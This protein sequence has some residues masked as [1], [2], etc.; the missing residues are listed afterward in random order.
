MSSSP[1]ELPSAIVD[2][3]WDLQET[4]FVSAVGLVILLYDHL[5][6]LPD[7][8]RFIWP[9]EF[10]SSK[11]LFLA[12]RYCVPCIMI[13]HTVQL[14][15][16]SPLQLTDTFCKAWYC[17]G[18]LLGWLTLAINDWLVMLRLWI[19]F[20]RNRAFILCTL[21][22]FIASNTVILVLSGIGFHDMIPTTRF[23]PLVHV[24][25]PD[26]SSNHIRVLW[27]PVLLFQ[28]MM[29]SALGWK[30][31]T[32]TKTFST[33]LRDGYLYFLESSCYLVNSSKSFQRLN[34][35]NTTIVLVAEASLMFV[36][37]FLVWCFTTTA[38][39][40]MILSLRRSSFYAREGVEPLDNDHDSP[41]G[42]RST[43][44]L[45]L[46]EIRNPSSSTSRGMDTPMQFND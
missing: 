19:L 42:Y 32:R 3:L 11:I 2:A 44:H 25:V 7:E 4:R 1:L 26:S 34:V 33:L 17:V 45:E 20:D 30:V 16:L 15:G 41:I 46:S 6:S 39:C 24:C 23:E 9:A 38:T 5:L 18:I 22:F 36:T 27:L 29:I 43:A 12:L 35:L 13:V 37:V 14:A 8:V 28:F 10:T 31:L 21:L 40:R